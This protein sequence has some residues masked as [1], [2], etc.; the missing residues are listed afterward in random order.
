MVALFFLEAGI[1]FFLKALKKPKYFIFSSL[2]FVL[3]IYS[4]Y[5]LRVITPLII[6]TLVIIY[7]W[8]FS[9]ISRYIGI[10]ILLGALILL[11]LGLSFIKEKDV[12]LGRA[13]TVSI[14][15]DQGVKL[16]QWELLT[17][18]GNNN[19][20]LISRFF[21]NNLYMY[22]KGIFQRFLSHFDGRYLFL[23]GDKA[24]PFQIPNMGI[25]YLMDAIFIVLG[26]YSLFR[27]YSGIR[28]LITLFL[29]ISFIPAAFTFM[30]PS[31]NRT[32]NAIIPLLILIPV[33]LIYFLE[34]ILKHNVIA[35]ST[36]DKLSVNSATWQSLT[37]TSSHSREIPLRQLADRNDNITITG[38]VIISILYAVS[39]SYFL[40]Q[41][42]IV[43]PNDYSNW[44]NYG[45]REVV[46]Y[47]NSIENKYD[48][49]IIADVNGMPYIYFLFYGSYD[50]A[51]YQ[52][53]SIRTYV[54]DRFGF[55]HVEGFGK[56]LFPNNF[57]WKY[58]KDNLQ[59][60]TLYVVPA[61]QAAGEEGF[62]K[63]IK[64]PNG[65]TAYKIFEYE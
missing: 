63:E 15:Y 52:K 4:Y 8:R 33:G 32:F 5:G 58:A 65:K 18:D 27:N 6:L 11:P 35:R 40:R 57:N 34:Y 61:D 29:I 37:D 22:G 39:F 44:W 12:V 49:V 36:F 7:R 14:F 46:R 25:L 16:R 13:R 51:K 3:S 62:T 54:A 55:E 30:T 9:F 64:F 1:L 17:Q 60:S 50:P 41:Y 59:K 42:F 53:E 21:H 31:S 23:E 20:P 2:F 38:K 48:N 47:V 56:Y 43:L 28:L 10:S 24:Q 26:I 45:W 19:N